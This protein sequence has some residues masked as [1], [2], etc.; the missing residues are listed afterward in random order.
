MKQR[1][2]LVVGV[3]LIAIGLAFALAP[4]EWIEETLGFEPD[5]GSGLVELLLALVPIV[6]G[7]ALLTMR[8]LRSTRTQQSGSTAPA[9][10]R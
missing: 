9:N 10:E 8:Y 2:M 3:L 1:S 4:K 7:V 5:G 6:V